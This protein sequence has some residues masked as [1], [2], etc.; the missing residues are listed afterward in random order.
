MSRHEQGKAVSQITWSTTS[1]KLSRTKSRA[2]ADPPHEQIAFANT[3]LAGA[4]DHR[5]SIREADRAV[6][7]LLG[8][9]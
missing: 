1:A 3:D 5:N 9:W 2:L 4:S 8:A 6:K 7:Q